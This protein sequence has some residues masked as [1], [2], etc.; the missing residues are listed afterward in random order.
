MKTTQQMTPPLT[1]SEKKLV[2]DYIRSYQNFV[3]LKSDGDHPFHTN[4]VEY[5]MHCSWARERLVKMY[6]SIPQRVKDEG[7]VP[8]IYYE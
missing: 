6:N 4:V 8:N 5:K 1:D 2:S 7:L 3:D